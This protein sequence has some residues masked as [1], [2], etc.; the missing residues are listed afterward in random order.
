MDSVQTFVL[1]YSILCMANLIVVTRGVWAPT[2]R[3]VCLFVICE[4]VY[5]DAIAVRL[6]HG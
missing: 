3:L 5:L 6:Q 1:N 2:G 4:S